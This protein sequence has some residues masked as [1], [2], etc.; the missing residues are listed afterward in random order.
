MANVK[1]TLVAGL[2]L[3]STF[4]TGAFAGSAITAQL[5]P[6][7]KVVVDGVSKQI[8]D[9]SGKQTSPIT[10][11]NTTY[12]PIRSVANLCGKE[13]GWD[14]ATQTI[15]LTSKGA[16]SGGST[17]A[18]YSRTNP[19]PIGT[20]QSVIIKDYA[21]TYN[22]SAVVQSV[23]RGASAWNKIKEANMFNDEAKAGYEYI[24]AKLRVSVNSVSDDSAMELSGYSFTAF[25]SDNVEYDLPFV[26]EPSP[27]FGGQVYAGGTSE[28]YVVFEV[29]KTDAKPKIVIGQDYRG[30]GGIWF[31]L[32]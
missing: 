20:I 31:A 25:S 2:V 11:N 26:V 14:Q 9:A 30:A 1:K 29:K 3:G 28:G 15:T 13:V 18:S 12:L 23:E 22:I 4:I 19:A 17:S 21:A 6:Q 5:S 8:T 32:Q 24:L 10:Y 27:Q 16:S 7:I